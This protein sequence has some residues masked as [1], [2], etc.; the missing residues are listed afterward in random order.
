MKKKLLSSPVI[1]IL[2]FMMTF[3]VITKN[4][5]ALM[6]EKSFLLEFLKV[7]ESKDQAK[8][9]ELVS[10]AGPHVV[11][12][13]VISQSDEGIRTV[14]KGKKADIPF[15]TAEAIALA[16]AKVFKKAGL[17]ELVRTYRK[18]TQEM[19][20]ELSKGDDLIVEGFG[21][22]EKG[23]WREA[24]SRLLEALKIYQKLGDVTGEF[25]SLTNIGLV[26]YRLGQYAEALRYHN[27]S[28]EIQRKIGDVAGESKSLTNIGNV[29]H[30]LGQY[31]EALRYHKQSLEIDRKIGDVA[32]ESKSRGNIGVV[33]ESLGQCA[34]AL[35]YHKQSL[36]IQ[37]KVGDVVGESISLANIGGIY[38]C[39]GQYVEALRYYH[40]S[41]EIDRKIGDVAG[42][43]ASLNN[44]GSVFRSLGQYS[45]AMQHFQESIKISEKIGALEMVWRSNRG[46]GEALRKSGKGEEAVAHYKKAVGV[47]E[48]LY[49]FTKGLKEEERSSM[50]GEKSFVYKEFIELLL[51]LHRKQPQKG[52]DKEAFTISE[53]SK[54][55]TFHELMAKVG[56]KI[57]FAGDETFKK[58]IG[59]EQQLIGELINLRGLLTKEVSKPEKQRNEELIKSLK[60]QLSKTEKTLTDLEKEIESKYPRYADLKK[61]KSLTAEELQ[62]ILKPG[63]TVVSY[64]VGKDKLAAFVIGKK[65]FKLIEIGTSRE[66]LSKLVRRFR[67]GLEDVSEVKDLEKF[68]PE[69]AYELYQKIFSPLISELKGVTKLYLS[70]DDILYTLP[71]EALVDKEINEKVFHEARERGGVYLSEYNTL[72]YLIDTYTIT[73]LPSASVLRSLRK[74]EKPGYGKWSKPLIAF[75]D[76]IFGPEGEKTGETKGVKGRGLNQETQFTA[77]LL[78]RSTGNERLERLKESAQE[79]EAISKELKG[80]KEDI[81]LREKATEENIYRTNLRDARYILFSTHGLLGGDFSGVAEPALALTL[82]DNSPGRDGFLTMSEVLGLD[83][84]SELIILSA[85]NTSGKGDKAGSGEGFVGL[86]RSFMF[87]GSKSLLVTHWSVESEA[88]KDLMVETFKNMNKEA[89]PEALRKAKLTMKSSI[90]QKGNEKISL[91]H[92]FFWAPFVLVGEGK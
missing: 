52:Y 35:K 67:R 10:Q 37:R 20:K 82:I 75:A 17:V 56:A 70:A 16:S 36:E 80:R 64:A 47:I 28:L 7:A 92:P 13:A 59:K 60:D 18:Y 25:R 48:E 42:E 3:T 90:T 58:M 88:A 32:G 26:F 29:Y 65:S 6:D 54:S 72:H 41:L 71:F 8:M 23:K 77:Q 62:G 11:Y 12:K 4:V 61:P 40:Q 1:I 45:K 31:A 49:Q 46:L 87:A 33:Y 30:G 91:S 76:P 51:E 55:R 86:T 57:A 50:I 68:K 44:I 81:Y 85:C 74:F 73:Y 43:G 19:C 34:E 84:N 79:A 9:E 78:T 2:I 53:K 24:Q 66:E 83:L 5:N 39:L 69:V 63:E 89:K 14:F 21:L 22:Y 15:N 38:D 27:Q